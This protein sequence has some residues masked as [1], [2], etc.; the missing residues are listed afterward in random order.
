MAS[1]TT[2][3]EFQRDNYGKVTQNT[4]NRRTAHGTDKCNDYV[5]ANM[6]TI[7]TG[8]TVHISDV[9]LSQ[10]LNQCIQ[11]L[12]LEKVYKG[13]LI[14]REMSLKRRGLHYGSLS[15]H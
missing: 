2:K 7:G 10:G 5:A 15:F 13:V 8:E 14:F 9:S 4:E 3:G 12:F 11:E 1:I 6:D